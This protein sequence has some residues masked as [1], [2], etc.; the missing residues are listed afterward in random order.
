ELTNLRCR[1]I[2]VVVR[3]TTGERVERLANQLI[4]EMSR[5]SFE[6]VVAYRNDRRWLQTFDAVPFAET[7]S[8]PDLLKQ[9]GVYVITGGLGSIGL[10]F[11]EYLADTVKAKLALIGR[12]PLP[13]RSEWERCLANPGADDAKRKIRSILAMEAA[14]AE[15]LTLSADTG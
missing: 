2:D 9:E 1:N 14:G 11:A 5:E 7:S 12:T 8:A 10:T 15:V 4:W 13:E 3:G 6:P